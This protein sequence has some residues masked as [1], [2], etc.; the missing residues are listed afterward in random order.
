MKIYKN[1]KGRFI[2]I[3]TRKFY[4]G[5]L[6]PV[7]IKKLYGQLTRYFGKRLKPRRLRWENISNKA[8]VKVSQVVGDR[9][10]SRVRQP[11]RGEPDITGTNEMLRN[12]IE[13]MPKQNNLID[14][15][16]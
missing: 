16:H 5:T 14:A 6:K 2:K 1:K 7:Q 4:V 11:T 12:K 3:G 9:T 8:I 15:R 10:P 13:N